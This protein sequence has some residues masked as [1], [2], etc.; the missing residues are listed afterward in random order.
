MG[1]RGTASGSERKGAGEVGVV[2]VMGPESPRFKRGVVG[3][4]GWGEKR[5]S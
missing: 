2:S 1:L 4:M 3:G 5:G